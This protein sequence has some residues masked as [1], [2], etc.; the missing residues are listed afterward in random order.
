FTL[1]SVKFSDRAWTKWIM[2]LA[3]TVLLV[4]MRLT[5]EDAP[6]THALGYFMIAVSILFFD[7]KVIWYSLVASVGVDI[8]MWNTFTIQTDVFIK[9]PR[10][11]AI[12]YCCYLWLALAAVF[13]VRAFNKLFDLAAKGEDEAKSMASRLQIILE[14]VRSLSTGLF[15]NTAALKDTSNDNS[16]SFKA[17]HTQAVSLQGISQDQA[18]HLDKNVTVLD[19]IGA[20]IRNVAENTMGISSRI[21]EFLS[22]IDMGNQAVGSQEESL[23]DSERNN[24]HIMKAVNDLEDNSLKIAS[25]VDTIMSIADQTN[26]L[27][28]NA[29]IEAA[30]AGEQ[31]RG[32]AVV[33]EEVRKLADD[34]KA[35]VSTIDAL[36]KSN[37]SSTENTVDKISESAKTLEEQR[38]AM[39]ATRNT[40]SVRQKESVAISNAVQE[41]S[42]CV[43]E[44]LASSEESSDLAG[45][46]A[47]LSKMASGCTDDI[48]SEIE[49][50]NA[51]LGRLEEQI[52]QFGE[53]ALALQTEANQNI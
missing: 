34:T 26:L 43:E 15:G 13:I 51:M 41:I 11:V 14:R 19:E 37:K 52:A 53:L 40:F 12:R 42:A 21:S 7:T 35:A 33:A 8:A 49:T 46:V 9:F 2:M 4:L 29:A 47:V 17:I 32:F 39:I 27:A 18:D 20:A 5:T 10:D 45:K 31:G 44:L 3:L 23:D 25:I 48:M 16:D 50:Y 30:R 36:V 24:Q 38:A 22:A 1:R 28:L 6:E